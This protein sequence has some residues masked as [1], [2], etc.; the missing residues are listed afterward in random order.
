MVRKIKEYRAAHQSGLLGAVGRTLLRLVLLIVAL[1]VAGLYGENL[2]AATQAHIHADSRWVYA[3]VVAGLSVV[4][5]V[6]YQ[7]PFVPS[8]R[9]FLWDF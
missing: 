7:L 4:T 5:I 8:Y 6:A 2:R 9:L 1:A 3:E